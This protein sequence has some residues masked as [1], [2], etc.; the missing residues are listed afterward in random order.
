MKPVHCGKKVQVPSST[1][2]ISKHKVHV[3]PIKLTQPVTTKLYMTNLYQGTTYVDQTSLF[4][5]FVLPF[6]L[7]SQ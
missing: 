4:L 1:E 6:D 5:I 7:Y 3:K 2:Y